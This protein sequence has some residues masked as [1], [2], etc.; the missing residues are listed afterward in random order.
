MNLKISIVGLLIVMLG[1]A[2]LANNPIEAVLATITPG[3]G[4]N[5]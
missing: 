4:I 1:T 3:Y 2:I 5:Y